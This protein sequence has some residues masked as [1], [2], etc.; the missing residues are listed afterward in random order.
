M[1]AT[2]QKEIV[3][4][5]IASNSFG[6]SKTY[7][8]LLVYLVECSLTGDIPKEVTIATDIFGKESF[9]PSESTLVRVYIY[10]LRKK[11][12]KYY[13][14]EGTDEPVLIRIPKGS[15]KVEFVSKEDVVD[16]ASPKKLKI[17]IGI[18]VI[19]I[20]SLIGNLYLIQSNTNKSII[21]PLW[22][23]IHASDKPILM[24]LGDLFV[25]T[26]YDSVFKKR[27]TIRDP[28]IN[29]MQAYQ[30]FVDKDNRVNSS[31]QPLTYSFLIR[32][33]VEW[34]K[35]MTSFTQS[36]N[37]DFQIRTASR[38]NAK[39]VGNYHIMAIG[40]IKTLQ[41]I[42]AF[43]PN[44]SFQYDKD[45]DAFVYT[46]PN[47]TESTIYK[48][49]GSADNHHKDYALL[50]KYPGFDDSVI[51]IF[52]GLW[53]SGASQALSHFS[54][55]NESQKLSQYLRNKFDELP[56]FYEVLFEVNGV[57]RMGLSTKILHAQKLG[58]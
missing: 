47:T 42:T 25:Y 18:G 19:L 50:A 3:E 39:E 15:Y 58:Q 23:D 37:K 20:I 29:N 12:K 5:I 43:N 54:D 32:N 17:G 52:A 55:P 13:Q 24:V 28:A 53:D 8:N 44:T 36:I 38:F 26:E 9:D 35:K 14:S 16:H 6:N 22:A 31:T 30:Q 45:Q 49:S 34:V 27:R 1:N 7:A 11:L 57:D 56:E 48:S 41:S 33:S 46:D 21:S 2:K 51:Y 4:R 40:M 10:N